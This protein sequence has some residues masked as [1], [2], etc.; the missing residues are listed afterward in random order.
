MFNRKDKPE[1]DNNTTPNEVKPPEGPT[2]KAKLNRSIIWIV[3]YSIISLVFLGAIFGLNL[4][5]DSL[6]DADNK[7]INE[8][9]NYILIIGRETSE[10]NDNLNLA[11]KYKER[12]SASTE[13]QR[14]SSGI[15]PDFI[16]T[17][18]EELVKKY[19]IGDHEFK[20]SVPE[21]VENPRFKGKMLEIYVS[22]CQITFNATDD[23]RAIGFLNEL[24][25]SITGYMMINELSLN[26]LRDYVFE[27]MVKISNG[28]DPAVISSKV[29]F[30]W[31][32]TKKINKPTP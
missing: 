10:A 26:K 31:Y 29:N 17:K 6:L 23:I 12:W 24:K 21:K 1:I 15:N 14:N 22:N 20:M 28:Q 7:N 19:N 27:D 30:K 25:D 2:Y 18:I 13:N 32:V 5:R 9:K 3:V 16:N 11:R 8:L 4:Y